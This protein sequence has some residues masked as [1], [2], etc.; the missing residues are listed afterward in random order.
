MPPSP[1]TAP[2]R[3]GAATRRL[4]LIRAACAIIAD[5]GFEGLRTRAVAARAKVNIATLHYY[6]PTKE[7]LIAGVAE[8]M[9]SLFQSIR[10][11]EPPQD[12]GTPPA[13]AAFRRE[14]ADVRYYWA[15]HRQ[16]LEVMME[17]TRRAQRDPAV[18]RAIRP[19]NEHWFSSILDVLVA[20]QQERVF[21]TDLD[22]ETLTMIVVTFLTGVPLWAPDPVAFDDACT[23]IEKLILRPS[24]R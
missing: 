17:L 20:G 11:P 3:P 6:F 19:L 21:R 13:L 10:S 12:R 15:H 18:R 16:M 24:S 2:H 4:A 14:L 1:S 22:A 7:A 23:T 5:R 9:A 8:Q